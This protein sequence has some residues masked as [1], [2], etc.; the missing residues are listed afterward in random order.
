[1][2]ESCEGGRGAQLREDVEGARPQML[3][4]SAIRQNSTQRAT[5]TMCLTIYNFPDVA[6]HQE[7]GSKSVRYPCGVNSMG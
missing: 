2:I 6:E 7:C 1:M 5:E 3:K 4:L